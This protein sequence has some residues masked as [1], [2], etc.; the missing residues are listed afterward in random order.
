MAKPSKRLP[1]GRRTDAATGEPDRQVTVML[2]ASVVRAMR[3]RAAELDETIR[4]VVL[5]ALL[6]DGFKVP[7]EE[8]ADRRIAAN[9]RRG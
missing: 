3:M 9:K 7:T 2:P 8:I 1:H 5:R 4:T 6:A